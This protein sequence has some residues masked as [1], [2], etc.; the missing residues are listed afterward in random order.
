M[1]RIKAKELKKQIGYQKTLLLGKILKYRKK[2]E[3]DTKKVLK[4][5]KS[6]EYENDENWKRKMPKS[7]KWKKACQDNWKWTEKKQKW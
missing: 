6:E 7:K 5:E 1:Q 4:S 2:I 3:E